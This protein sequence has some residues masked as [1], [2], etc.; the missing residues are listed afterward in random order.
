MAQRETIDGRIVTGWD[1]KAR[2]NILRQYAPQGPGQG[3][4]FQ[5]VP[6][7]RHDAL[8]QDRQGIRRG[9]QIINLVE[10]IV[11]KLVHEMGLSDRQ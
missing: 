10:A 4:L 9:H 8:L 5:A 2:D 6:G 1:I 7:H 11:G 3:H